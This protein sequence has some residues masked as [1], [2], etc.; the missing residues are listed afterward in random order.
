MLNGKHTPSRTI[1]SEFVENEEVDRDEQRRQASIGFNQ[2]PLGLLRGVTNRYKLLSRE[3]SIELARRANEE[4]DKD[5]RDA[6]VL[7]N[8]RLALWMVRRYPTMEVELLDR[9]QEAII[10]ILMAID[11]FDHTLGFSF[12]THAQWW[13]RSALTRQ[14]QNH[15][16]MIREP[17]HLQELRNKVRNASAELASELKRIPT[18][19]EIATRL[20]ITEKQVIASLKKLRI[21]I[22]SFDAPVPALQ[23]RDNVPT[24]GESLPDDSKLDPLQ[25][26]E[27]KEEM[28]AACNVIESLIDM[29]YKNEDIG[30]RNKQ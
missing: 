21:P 27:A 30:D 19:L 28:Q 9:V 3:K 29:L 10:G 5:A 13:I 23:Y 24:F 8:I 25:M 12:T 1:S 18:P 15:K 26:L 17:V 22:V 7:H 11:K 6:L 16:S 4:N 20:N 14:W 2:D